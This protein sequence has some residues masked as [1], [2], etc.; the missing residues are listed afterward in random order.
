VHLTKYQA[1]G[2]DY[3]VVE[4]AELEAPLERSHVVA[5]CDRHFGVGADGILVS[6]PRP[7][8]FG[9]RIFNPDGSE[10]EKSGNGLRI[11]ARH[12]WDRKQVDEEPFRVQTAG[13][14]VRCRVHPGGG[15][16]SVEMGRV[17]FRSGDVPVTGPDREVLR[18]HLALSGEDVEMNAA[19]VGN[20]HCVLVLES[21]SEE[22][23]RE[24]GREIEC[25]PTFPRRTNVQL[26]QVEGRHRLRIEIWERGAGYT[27]ASGTSSCAAAA[28]SI[29]LGLCASPV[30]VRMPGGTLSVE[31]S[32]D[33]GA[34]LTGAVRKVAEL[35]LGPELLGGRHPR[36]R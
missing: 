17:S 32:A 1:V 35:D 19:S 16:V 3:L 5:I 21:V 27:L 18:E 29:R 14:T 6:E 12:L 4:A 7:A 13:G 34:T 25:H 8:G 22:R 20:P 11:H 23:A 33:S 31:L 2:N 24:L 10:A 28:V 9:L 15:K 36:R 26:A 30:E